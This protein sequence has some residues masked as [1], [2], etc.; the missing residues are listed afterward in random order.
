MY[1]TIDTAQLCCWQDPCCIGVLFMTAKTALQ[2]V[3]KINSIHKPARS[4][5]CGGVVVGAQN[6]QGPL[7]QALCR[8][9]SQL[10]APPG[11]C[12]HPCNLNRPPRLTILKLNSTRPFMAACRFI[13]WRFDLQD[14][15]HATFYPYISM[16][17]AI[18]QGPWK[19]PCASIRLA[20]R[21]SFLYLPCALK[22]CSTKCLSECS[23]R[24]ATPTKPRHFGS[25]MLKSIGLADA[26]G[27]E[28]PCPT[29]CSA[30][31]NRCL[32]SVPDNKRMR[33]RESPREDSTSGTLP[34]RHKR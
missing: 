13:F 16:H 26:F 12:P 1:H 4:G 30:A 18:F 23:R 11:T 9:A 21:R 22:T 7:V 2:T 33:R 14:L 34:I 24:T 29:L 25:H 19:T 31:C 20:M 8:Q 15:V 3:I 32:S 5:T 10:Q 6:W 28:T 27:T 17:F